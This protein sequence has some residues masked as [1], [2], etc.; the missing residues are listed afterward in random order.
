M[1][2]F[3]NVR[4]RAGCHG[5]LSG[6]YKYGFGISGYNDMLGTTAA[7]FDAGSFKGFQ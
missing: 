6:R 1:H 4:N 5:G 2:S 3:I 7:V